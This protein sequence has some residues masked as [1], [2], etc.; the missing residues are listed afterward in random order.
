MV[1]LATDWDKEFRDIAEE[2][3]QA[4]EYY[5]GSAR[6]IVRHPNR[7]HQQA[8]VR[9][10][11]ALNGDPD[12]DAKPRT[13]AVGGVEMEFF[14]VGQLAA[15]IGRKPGTIRKWESLGI[16]PKATYQI[17]GRDGDD[18]G[19]RRLYSRAQVEGLI[20]ICEEEGMYA[21]GR[22]PFNET[23]FKARVLELFKQTAPKEN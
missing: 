20:L 23:A 3:K 6:P 18:R 10:G 16:I 2:I 17:P 7:L 8:S 9:R 12:W 4:P 13:F 14:T 19:R 22:K 1:T 15:A 5:P 11:Q 21:Y